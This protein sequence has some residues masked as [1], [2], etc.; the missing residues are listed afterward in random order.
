MKKTD[1]GAKK[2]NAMAAALA[3]LCCLLFCACG[4]Q[5]YYVLMEPTQVLRQPNASTIDYSEKYFDF[6][7]REA[8][9]TDISASFN[10]LGTAVY[11][12]IFNNAA[13]ITS[14]TARLSNLNS[15]NDYGAA[16]RAM[17]ETYRYQPLNTSAGLNEPFIASTG[18]DRR[19]YI[20][21]MNYGAEERYQAKVI[22]NY[23]GDSSA[24]GASAP[25]RNMG[26][27]NYTFDFGRNS[28]SSAGENN[29][30]PQSGDVDFTASGSGSTYYVDLYAAAVGRD[31]TYTTY[32]SKVLHLGTVAID[33]TQSDN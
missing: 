6:M 1:G 23:G 21:L 2:I 33:A 22:L 26:G 28:S 9:N 8:D 31:T 13:D 12:K 29:R 5:E 25:R 7:T 14:V 20:R 16:A 17:I 24:A 10:F 27:N 11:Y 19:V 32:Y 15:S 30:P 3:A 18:A 4:L